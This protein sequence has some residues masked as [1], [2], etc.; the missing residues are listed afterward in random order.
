[1]RLEHP[2]CF[3][4]FLAKIIGKFAIWLKYIPFQFA[5]H[6]PPLLMIRG[7]AVAQL[8]ESLRYNSESRGFDSGRCHWNF[9]LT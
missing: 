1:M 8:V 7:Y 4:F 5:S 6:F 3:F 9:S 2:A